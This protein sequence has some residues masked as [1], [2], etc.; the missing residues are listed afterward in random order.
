[1]IMIYLVGNGYGVVDY[2]SGFSCY[3]GVIVVNCKWFNCWELLIPL[4]G[5]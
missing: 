2:R 3:L 4:L 5:C 1:M